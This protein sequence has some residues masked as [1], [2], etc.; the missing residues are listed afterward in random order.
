MARLLSAIQ[1]VRYGF[2]THA[3]AFGA[4]QSVLPKL[5]L[6]AWLITQVGLT[7]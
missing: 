2:S 6:R 5:G 7:P 1:L 3:E 4:I